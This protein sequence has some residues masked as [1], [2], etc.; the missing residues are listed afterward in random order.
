MQLNVLREHMSASEGQWQGVAHNMHD[1][2]QTGAM[3]AHTRELGQHWHVLRRAGTCSWRTRRGTRTRTAEG[4]E[5][6]ALGRQHHVCQTRSTR[7]SVLSVHAR[8][9]ALRVAGSDSELSTL[10]PPLQLLP[11]NFRMRRDN[12]SNA[13]G[14]GCVPHSCASPTFMGGARRRA[15]SVQH[16]T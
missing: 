10:T 6:V 16:L 4:E 12:G 9:V 15:N 11:R 8:G 3:V 13:M 1:T 2:W 7:G 5:L 14:G